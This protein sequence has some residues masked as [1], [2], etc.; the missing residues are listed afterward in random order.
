MSQE[1]IE[2]G[3]GGNNK[4]FVAV[5]NDTEQRAKESTK[6]VNEDLEKVGAQGIKARSKIGT[7]LNGIAADFA[8]C[9][10]VSGALEVGL[11]RIG[12]ALKLGGVVTIASAFGKA[13][14]D[15]TQKSRDLNFEIEKLG[16]RNTG[17]V[18]G[19]SMSE[20]E[21]NFSDAKAMREN[22]WGTMMSQ[23]NKPNWLKTAGS[24]W[25]DELANAGEFWSGNG[26]KT[27]GQVANVRPE[28]D[29]ALR[30]IQLADLARI[31]EKEKAIFEITSMRIKGAKELADI[32][33][34]EAIY[35]ERI[36]SAIQKAK[37]AGSSDTSLQQQ[38]MAERDAVVASMRRGMM[39]GEESRTRSETRSGMMTRQSEAQAGGAT[40][41]ELGRLRFSDE[42]RMAETELL[43]AENRAARAPGDPQAALDVTLAQ[44]NLKRIGSEIKLFTR[45][46]IDDGTRIKTLNQVAT[47]ERQE[48]R[49]NMEAIAQAEKL[50]RV[51]LPTVGRAA[52]AT[53]ILSKK[54]EDTLTGSR[55]AG[56]ESREGFAADG[57]MFSRG[58]IMG[59]RLAGLEPGKGFQNT[60]LDAM[61]AEA[62]MRWKGG[63][64]N[65]EARRQEKA[66][67]FQDAQTKSASGSRGVSTE[68]S[69]AAIALQLAKWDA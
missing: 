66:E 25:E 55:L 5:L 68:D 10:T 31:E 12:S 51:G 19:F 45:G 44:E 54:S 11:G 32:K 61:H 67:S 60:G 13:I 34:T 14:Y 56:M 9:T 20:L 57:S 43:H 27:L 24:F 22:N 37:D 21:G 33:Q 42:R 69:L 26:G 36:Q 4:G 16:R 18:S 58:P 64:A 38:L 8:R 48:R 1:A 17:G 46:L 47:S 50:E 30:K 6:K 59:S 29:E 62:E 52:R 23:E 53:K 49:H 2:F 41:M 3:I 65:A 40:A 39:T 35:A 28:R 63:R 15:A 7:D